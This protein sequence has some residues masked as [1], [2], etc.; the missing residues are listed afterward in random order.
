MNVLLWVLQALAALL[1]AASGFMEVFMFDK[2][3]ADVPFADRLT[4]AAESRCSIPPTTTCS[5]RDVRRGW[6]PRRYRS[7]STRLLRT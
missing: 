2:I 1:Y 5:R 3:S 7:G 6:A 4:D